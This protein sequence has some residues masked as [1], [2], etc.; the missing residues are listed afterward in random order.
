QQMA[1]PMPPP[2]DFG[3]GPR[4]AGYPTYPQGEYDRYDSQYGASFSRY[5]D[6]YRRERPFSPYRDGSVSGMSGYA[7]RSPTDYRD[8]RDSPSAAQVSA[9]PPPARDRRETRNGHE[10]KLSP[11]DAKPRRPH[12]P[13]NVDR[14]VSRAAP[15]PRAQRTETFPPS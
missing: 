5:D 14:T 9:A 7:A 6:R 3:R 4:S 10:R 1:S 12:Q 11:R 15:E 13:P 2:R 8:Y